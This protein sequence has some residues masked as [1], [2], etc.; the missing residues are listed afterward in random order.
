MVHNKTQLFGNYVNK[1]K[2]ITF[3]GLPKHIE[4]SASF[5]NKD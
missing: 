4:H 5:L 1:V 3:N 2:L